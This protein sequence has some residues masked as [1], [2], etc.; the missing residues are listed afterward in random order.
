[1]QPETRYAKS[2]DVHVAYQVFGRGPVDLVI[3]PPF[4]SNVESF[5][6]L[7]DFSRWFLRLGAYARVATFDKR[8]TGMS[9]RVAELADL[10]ARMDDIR[11]VM[12]AAGME[13]PALLGISEGG[14]M[15]ALFA[16]T[17]PAHCRALVLYGSCARGGARL[18]TP[19]AFAAFLKD[20][21]EPGWGA[22]GA[23]PSSRR[24]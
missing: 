2:G 6:E 21:V 11:A 9:D 1:M 14:T 5:W 17:H 3:S 12:D 23:C 19:E 7:P 13:R 24:R 4:V 10:D 18:M 20:V 22:A 15:S 16:A 8:G